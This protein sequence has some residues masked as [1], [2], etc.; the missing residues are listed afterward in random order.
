LMELHRSREARQAL[1]ETV[2]RNPLHPHAYRL[3]AHLCLEAG[4][5]E[6]AQAQLAIHRRHWP[7]EREREAEVLE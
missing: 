5:M 6:Q 4:E 3:L 1:E 7:Q 2:R